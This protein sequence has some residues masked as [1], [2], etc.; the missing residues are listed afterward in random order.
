MSTISQMATAINGK[1]ESVLIERN[2]VYSA[3]VGQF[4]SKMEDFFNTFEA[5]DAQREG[6]ESAFET[7][8]SNA[9]EAAKTK[10]AGAIE[11]LKSNTDAA[12]ID[13][14]TEAYSNLVAVLGRADDGLESAM[15]KL[16]REFTEEEAAELT[17]VKNEIG[18]AADVEAHLSDPAE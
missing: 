16:I 1:L 9:L 2:N 12:A 13:S 7:A 15:E 4:K 18:S 5:A 8:K 6:D 3:A 11:D 17:V 10:V 14:I